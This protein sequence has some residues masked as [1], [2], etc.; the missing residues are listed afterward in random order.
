MNKDSLI[1]ELT[2]HYEIARELRN[3][4]KSIPRSPH[5]DNILKRFDCQTDKVRNLCTRTLKS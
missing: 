3:A 1:L 4:L 2:Q 5:I